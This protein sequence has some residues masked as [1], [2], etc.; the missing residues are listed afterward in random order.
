MPIS[1]S[2]RPS[3]RCG[4]GVA[5]GA[6]S[7]FVVA[8][9]LA[10]A[11]CRSASK[12]D[13][14]PATAD[15]TENATVAADA[16]TTPPGPAPAVSQSGTSVL[17]TGSPSTSGDAVSMLARL[18]VGVYSDAGSGR[19]EDAITGG[20]SP[21]PIRLLDTQAHAMLLEVVD[22]QG[23]LG[24]TFDGMIGTDP[25]MPPASFLVAGWVTGSTSPRAAYALQLMGARR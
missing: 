15:A 1:A 5:R 20:T 25:G 17:G 6:M 16:A 4:P 22:G 19:P 12:N 9:L 18:G 23:L 7:C 24:A 14:A 11:S 10:V 21:S 13:G 2:K 8:S 3:P